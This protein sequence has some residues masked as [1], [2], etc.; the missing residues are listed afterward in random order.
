MTLSIPA[1]QEIAYTS[2]GNTALTFASITWLTNDLVI[3]WGV[4]EDTGARTLGTPTVAGLTFSLLAG[5][6]LAAGSNTWVAGWQAT[7]AAGGSG[8]VSTTPTGN[9]A[10]HVG[11]GLWQ[12]RGHDGIGVIGAVQAGAAT[13]TVSLTV[14]ANS[15]VCGV[16]GDWNATA[17]GG[18]GTPTVNV[19]RE[20]AVEAGAYSVWSAD[21]LAQAAGTRGYGRTSATGAKSTLGFVEVKELATSTAPP[22]VPNMPTRVAA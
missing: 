20:D 11:A 10:Q 1:Y 15:G 14:S 16:W 6:P 4:C 12:W 17:A 7:A 13:A 18:T 8:T 5:F 3:V 9:T 22:I 21:W 19:E 2:T